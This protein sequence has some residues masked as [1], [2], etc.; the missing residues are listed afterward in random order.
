VAPVRSC[1]VSLK[2][3]DGTTHSITVSAAT[4]F[5]AAAAAVAAFRQEQWAADS[6]TPN[7]TLR[8]EVHLPPVV[9]EVPFKALERWMKTP[10]T[11]PREEMVKRVAGKG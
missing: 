6:L 11:S 3:L 1:L 8:V 4:L 9:H 2:A 10:S 5:E 7:A